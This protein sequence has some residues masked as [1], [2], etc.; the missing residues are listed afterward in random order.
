MPE[1]FS[2]FRKNVFLLYLKH[3]A[4]IQNSLHKKSLEKGRSRLGKL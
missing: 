3:S 4:F 1:S 2:I